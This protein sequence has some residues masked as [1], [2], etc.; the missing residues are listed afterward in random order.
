MPKKTKEDQQI[1]QIM[2]DMTVN[3]TQNL[4]S[5][6]ADALEKQLTET[7]AQS[8]MESEFYRRLTKDMRS[9]LRKIYKE[10]NQAQSGQAQTPAIDPGKVVPDQIFRDA[11]EQ[12]SAV[13][14]HTENAT[15]T[16]MAIMEKQLETNDNTL[17]RI[18]ALEKEGTLSEDM[19]AFRTYVESQNNDFLAVMTSLSFQDLTGQRIKR[20]VSAMQEL[21]NTVLE[22]YISSGMMMKAYEEKPGQMDEKHIFDEKARKTAIDIKEKVVGSELKG[23]SSGTSQADIDDLLSQLGL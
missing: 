21:E 9:G 1:R 19:C 23:P 22:L 20:V 12:L 14:E 3:L 4:Q 6:L 18:N 11:S 17:A 8:L 5:V 10:M 13:L 16:I 2:Q 7:L 15:N